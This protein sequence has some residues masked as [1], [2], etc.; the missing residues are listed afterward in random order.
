MRWIAD[1]ANNGLTALLALLCVA[2]SP[3]TANSFTRNPIDSVYS[4][5]NVTIHS[6][7]GRVN[8]LSHFDLSFALSTTDLVK[9]SLEPNHDIFPPDGLFVNV[10]DKEGRLV[11]SHVVDRLAHK[12]YKGKTWTKGPNDKFWIPAGYS[13]VTLHRDGQDPLFEGVFSVDNDN[14]HVQTVR[15]YLQTRHADD[16]DVDDTDYEHMVMYRDSDILREPTPM[17]GRSVVADSI[18]CAADRMHFN[19]MPEHPVLQEISGRS[20]SSWGTMSVRSLFGKRQIDSSTGGNSA[21]VNLVSTIGSMAGCPTTRKVALVGVAADCTYRTALG[22]LNATQQNIINQMNQA[23]QVYETSFD[24]TLGLANLTVMDPECPA[25]PSEA[26]PWNQ[27]CSPSFDIGARLNTFSAWRGNLK[28]N[29]SHWTLLSTC[30]TNSEV[31]LAWLGQACVNTAQ[32]SNTTNSTGGAS[33]E[34][35]SGA[36]VV[37]RT[38]GVSEWQI[39]AH[40]T[41]HTFGAVHDCTAQTCA[42]SQTVSS[43]QCCPLSSGTCDAGEKYIMN[44]STGSGI[45]NFSPCSIGNICSAMGRNSVRS[46]CL[47][48]NSNVHTFSGPICGNGIVEPG[49]QCD[50][51]GVAGCGNNTCCDPTTCKFMNNAVCDDSNSDCCHQCQFTSAGTVCRA[52]T[53]VCDPQE[54]C[55]GNSSSCPADILAPNGQNCGSGLQ[56][57]SGQCTSRDQQCQSVMGTH[58]ANNDTHACDSQGCSIS[59]ASPSFGPGVCYEMPQNFLDGTTCGGGGSCSNVSVFAACH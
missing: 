58:A 19:S 6:S 35:V 29:N 14:H 42:N 46:S 37:I 25:T 10:L 12:V 28:D 24:I 9:L 55:P 33:T 17:L 38:E 27:A 26:T 18:G 52:S 22:S 41:G 53:S 3:S 8:A 43:S 4:L 1:H 23:S 57:A 16:P 39:I 44:P 31:G 50:C 7:G 34:T 49:E 40:E 21:G 13:R 32:T 48:D 30:P 36:N 15:N 45:T 47:T 2:V 51:G 5:A 59:C 54:V 20:I 11:S 56:C